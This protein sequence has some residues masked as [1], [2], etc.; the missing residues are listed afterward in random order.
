MTHST[1]N[2]YHLH[3]SGQV[4]GVGFRP[5]VWRLAREFGLQGWVNNTTDGVHIL[6]N[7][8]EAAATAFSEKI[9]DQAP[10]LSLVTGHSLQKI[11][12]QDFSDFQIVHSIS[13]AAPDLLLTPDF[14]LCDACRHELHDPANRRFG[15]PFITCTNCGPRFSIATGLPYDRERTT[16]Q[17]F[18]Q[19]PDC[20]AEYGNPAD[21]RYFSQTNSCPACG[22]QLELVD[23]DGAQQFNP[24]DTALNWL[25]SGKILAAKGIGGYLLLCDATNAPALET[26]RNRKHRPAKPFALLYANADQ[27]EGDA[28]LHP[29]E[30][31][32]LHSPQAPI[33][34]L[35][36]REKPASGLCTALVA[37]GLTQ[38]GA[39][40]PYAPL[41]DLLARGA[42]RPLVA[43]SGNISGSPI[44]FEDD[45]ARR[46]LLGIADGLLTH[47]RAI[48]IPQDDS[49]L[50]F[51]PT[52][53]QAIVLR[54]SR[55]YAPTIL[56][57]KKTLQYPNNPISQYPNIPISQS[58]LALGATMKSAFAWQHRSSLYLS[59]YLGELGSFDTQQAF[60]H[61]LTHF[62]DLL[63]EKPA[64]LVVD[65]HPD[66]FSTQ[67]G[68]RLGQE[69]NIPVLEVQHHEAH[70]GAVLAENGYFRTENKLE[71]P[72]L[73]VIWDGTGY[74]NDGQ[75]WGGEFFRFDGTDIVRAG[76][77]EPFDFLLGDKMPREPR[78]SAI[79]LARLSGI[80]PAQL[81]KQFSPQEW[82]LYQKI[83][84][85]GGLLHTTSVG[86]LFD[87]VAALLGL[88]SVSGF[89][90]Q[91]A[92]LLE[93]AAK[94]FFQKNG[95]H[96]A[97]AYAPETPHPTLA[98]TGALIR[99]VME[100]WTL[101]ADTERVG[102][103]F[104]RTLIE[105]IRQQ[106]RHHH[107]AILAFSGGVWQ[108]G[109][110]VDL[111]I[112]YLQP[113]FELLF[114]R[115]VSPNDEGVALGQLFR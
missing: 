66:Y 104:H 58:K 31:K 60:G 29:D 45:K 46:E 111:A 47:N 94:R 83:L 17:A 40:L 39:M 82:D 16:M 28:W 95:L 26:L 27:L 61:C 30:K 34:L 87:G 25:L 6:F 38:I 102:A 107:C 97:T 49:V 19:C 93:Q 2:T 37:P 67:L 41:L 90:G 72:V 1:E 56:F 106:A 63:R 14:G 75:V 103:R 18:T 115:Q 100:D 65:K 23:A 81:P 5:F 73:G 86:R 59:Q 50:H 55:G 92:M 10:R 48:A 80:L 12:K 112:E 11:D 43:T 114:H 78:I 70:F 35:P 32:L 71:K 8:D 84:S 24:L 108:N 3:L 4:Q 62:L 76:H 79:S 36:L 57:S 52:H 20:L 88:I 54:R 13:E 109:L 44:I 33:V 99:N 7:A 113:E 22:I 69:W 64:Q 77:F 21:R 98:P 89:E 68:K 9:L 74:G 96:A 42:G 85:R 15:Y 53:R 101:N 110:L 105:L 91:A 51:S